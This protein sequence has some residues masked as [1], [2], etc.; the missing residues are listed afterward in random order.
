MGLAAYFIYQLARGFVIMEEADLYQ[1]YLSN[2]SS[3]VER[4]LSDVAS[5]AHNHVQEIE[6]SLAQP[7]RMAPIMRGIVEQNPLIRSCGISFVA[8]YYPRQGR[9][10]CP[11]AARDDSGQ[12]TTQ[13]IGDARR[14]YLRAEWFTD[15]LKAGR[16][17]WSKAYFE[18]D[19][20]LRPQVSYLVPIRDRQGRTV[21]I[22]GADLPL[23]LLNAGAGKTRGDTS[24]I[25]LRK[26]EGSGSVKGQSPS[27]LAGRKWRMV[28]VDFIID[29]EGRYLSHPDSAYI[30]R[31]NYFELAKETP[32]S[33]DDHLGRLMLA[34][35]QGTYDDGEEPVPLPFFDI[36]E[37][38]SYVFYQPLGNTGW[39]IAQV[40][41]RLM[42]DGIAVGLGVF[43]ILLIGVGL[44]VTRIAGRIIIRRITRPLGKLAESAGEVAKG[45]F[46]AP[47]PTI[48]HNDEIKLLRDSFDGM[49][50]SLTRYVEELKLTTAS[51]AAIENEL[52]V[53]H[54]IQMSML[55][56]TFPPF[57]ERSD[58][59]IFG[60]LTPAKDVGG[61]LFD[62]YIRDNQLFFCIGDVSGK[63]V[64]A[65]LVMAMTRSLFRNISAHV[66]Q[67][68]QIAESLNQALADGNDTS[69]F[70]TAF[71]G[72]LDLPTGCLHYCNAGHN[73]PL[74]IRSSGV[75]LLPCES[76][77]I[78]GLE[79][80]LPFVPQEIQLEPQTALFLFTDGLNEAE[81]IT[82]D[83]FGD[84]R[85]LSEAEALL[86]EGNNRPEA[87]VRRMADA[88]HAFVGQAEQSD[89]LTM[90]AIKYI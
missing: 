47:L 15:A 24:V 31:K 75:S 51:K 59:D 83:Q 30:L 43:L 53:A 55:P 54:D 68:R 11:Y 56:K 49:Q 90:L 65:S 42:I 66:S 23:S 8:D 27:P 25:N 35:S 29:G 67:P 3:K 45:N 85:I 5:A 80:G 16:P 89:D 36:E 40:V 38:K 87:I 46:N 28:T 6:E 44:L 86:A 73:P 52:R 79:A 82:H 1:S 77:F 32:D 17:H 70:V 13:T 12:V 37:M 71:I 62:F 21:A 7:D 72:V 76:N 26:D 19:D 58:I 69:M 22:L 64:P 18:H 20:T 50:H 10:F 74:L 78:L 34:G 48:R 4:V 61:D 84:D 81:N 14:D 41:P 88:V 63:G 9:W 60:S 33:I 39:S 57:P 2:N